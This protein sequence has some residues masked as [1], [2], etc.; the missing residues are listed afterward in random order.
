MSLIADIKQ[1]FIYDP[2][3]GVFI[4]NGKVAG[5]Q[6]KASGYI[7]IMYQRKNYF[8]H[9]L[10]FLYMTGEWPS[11][12]VDHIDLNKSNNSWNN[13]RDIPQKINNQNVLFPKKKNK[14]QVLGV[15]QRGSSFTASL[16]LNKK[17]IHLGTFKTVA[18]AHAAYVSAKQNYHIGSTL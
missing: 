7:K 14:L 13:L 5:Y 4:R 10:A 8:A 3:S 12:H 1:E 2:V 15:R 17:Q 18:E 6:D 9:R 16:S 11:N